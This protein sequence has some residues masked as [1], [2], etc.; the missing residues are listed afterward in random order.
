VQAL[1]ILFGG[2]FTVAVSVACGRLLLR[3]TATDIGISFVFGAAVL[4]LAVFCLAAADAVYAP[5][6]LALGAALLWAARRHLRL[7]QT[8][9]ITRKLLLYALLPLFL[10][11][12]VIYLVHAMAP[13][14]SPD[15]AAYHLALVARYLGEHG[16]HPITTNI[17]AS[18]S[19]GIEMLFLFAFAFGKHSAAALV[20]FAFLLALVWQMFVYSRRAGF[21]VAGAC[22]AFLVFASPVVGI[23]ASSA[24]NDVAVAAIGFTLFQLLELWDTGRDKRLLVAIGVVAGFAYAAKYTAALAIPYALGYVAW[25]SRRW[26][27]VAVVAGC[28]LLLIVPWIVK[29]WLWVHNPVSPF[30]NSWFPNPYVTT[31]FEAEYR[32]Y[33]TH[34]ELSSLREI[35]MQVTTYGRLSGVLGPVF[36]LAPLALLAS[37]RREGRQLLLAALV[38]GSPYFSN[39]GARFLIAPLPFIA[40]ALALVLSRVPGLAFAVVLVHAYLSWPSIV[41][42]YAKEDAWRLRGVPWREALRI[43]P[44]GPYL[45]RWLPDYGAVRLIEAATPPGSTIFATQPLPEAY[46]SR[47]VLVEYYS[48]EN[49]MTGRILRTGAVAGD[50]PTLRLRFGFAQQPLRALRVVQTASGTNLWSI[51]ELRIYDGARELPRRP[52]WRL[53]ARPFAWGI[54]NAFDNSLIT[55]W[56]SGDSLRPGMYVQVD[57]G[58]TQAAD[59]VE[60]ATAPN[61]WQVRLELRG[62]SPDGTWKLLAASPQQSEE[63]KPLGWRRAV[64]GELKRR[65]IDY[66]VI[67]DADQ[68]ADDLRRNADRWG[69]RQIGQ[70]KALRLYQLP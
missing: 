51:N 7:P 33:L 68:G 42:K 48:A 45:E 50:A 11:Y 22:A 55:L 27:D 37:F 69:I 28:A 64:A 20:H 65:G 5:V 44:E 53:R 38:F 46:T 35:P 49:Q 25:K 16:F 62:Q 13:E 23:D 39:I 4:S 60:I 52:E 67:F 9:P 6:F 18:L 66:V 40:L 31:S 15:G 56:I 43:R 58:A 17:Y 34:Y 30:F 12:F 70:T 24:Y 47:R 54:Q 61:Q 10:A 2:G 19:Q 26:R 21:P 59:S 57:F 41:P 3:N 1:L 32:E 63:A 14:V 36:L 8:K 29:N